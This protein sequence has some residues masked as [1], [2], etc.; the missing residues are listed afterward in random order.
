MASFLVR[1]LDL[2]PSATDPFTDDEGNQHES[3]IN[4]L[5]ASGITS[6]CGPAK[7]CPKLAV[8]REQMA[9]FLHRALD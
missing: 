7:F 8:S 4:A 2:P 3:D 1:A 6:G 9:A 5:A